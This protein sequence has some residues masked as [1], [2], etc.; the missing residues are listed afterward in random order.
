MK[1]ERD[2][3]RAKEWRLE[4]PD[5]VKAQ[6]ARKRLRAKGL[7]EP[8]VHPTKKP[9]EQ[10]KA[11]QAARMK[12]FHASRQERLKT[13]PEFAIAYKARAR[14]KDKQRYESRKADPVAYQEW[15]AHKREQ[16][17][18][19]Y[20]IKH[21]IPLDAPHRLKISDEER[22]LRKAEK[23]RLKAERA[24][25]RAAKQPKLTPEERLERRRARALERYYK[26]RDLERQKRA[27]EVAEAMVRYPTSAPT[28]QVCPDPPE[29]QALFAKA[30]KGERPMHHF[31]GKKMG[32]FTARLKWL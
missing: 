2:K 23:E 10:A 12:R 4:N 31:T 13:D 14:A 25:I 15:L 5:K 30:S 32:A 18:I 1:S 3:Q 8:Y 27:A 11:E 29:L 7:L 28:P 9:E 22:A 16:K 21:G 19:R 24:A 17:F 20:R 26:K 6:Q